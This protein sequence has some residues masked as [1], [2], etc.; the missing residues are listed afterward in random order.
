LAQKVEWEGGWW[1]FY[2][3]GW[4]QQRTGHE[5]VDD[6]LKQL[7]DMFVQAEQIVNVLDE[8]LP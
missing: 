7:Q 1:D 2:M 4:L 3:W 5:A 6:L 8:W